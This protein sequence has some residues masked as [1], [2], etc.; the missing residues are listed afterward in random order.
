[1][2]YTIT[3]PRT[4]DPLLGWLSEIT[5]TAPEG[6]APRGYQVKTCERC[7]EVTEP[8]SD[9]EPRIVHRAT[10]WEMCSS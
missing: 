5:L 3:Y 10:G 9:Y 1:M 2:P 7:G 8:Y 4:R 6:W